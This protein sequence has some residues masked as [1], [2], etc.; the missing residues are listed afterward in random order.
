MNAPSGGSAADFESGVQRRGVVT[1]WYVSADDPAAAILSAP[2]HGRGFGRKFLA[3]Y[4]QKLPVAPIGDFPLNRSADSGPGEF[5]IGGVEGVAVVQTVLDD[6]S[7][8]SGLPRKLR[9]EIAASDVYASVSDSESGFGAFAHWHA[10]ELKRAYSATR[11]RTLEDTGL[12]DPVEGDYWAGKFRPSEQ[13]GNGLRGGVG[14]PFLPSALA[15]AVIASWLGFDPKA[16]ETDIPVSA[17]AVD[18]RR[19]ATSVDAHAHAARLVEAGS[20]A[21]DDS[22]RGYDDYE[23]HRGESSDQV[24]DQL[25]RAGSKVARLAGRLWSAV[26]TRLRR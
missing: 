9:E 23:E 12:P 10:G 13:P 21:D 16:P 25:A 11:F 15:D 3:L 4:D 2:P 17:F 1:L 8:L 19:V 5:Y 22:H 7:R 24:R 20:V 18:G 26:A 6:V 14:L